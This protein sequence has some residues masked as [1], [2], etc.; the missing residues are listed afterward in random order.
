MKKKPVTKRR[1]TTPLN[2]VRSTPLVITSEQRSRMQRNKLEAKRKLAIRE[3]LA[4][5]DAEIL[6]IIEKDP[7]LRTPHPTLLGML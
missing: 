2:L 6:S 5:I 4:L 7:R 3:Q 1:G